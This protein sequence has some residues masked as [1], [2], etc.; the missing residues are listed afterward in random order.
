MARHAKVNSPLVDRHRGILEP[1]PPCP[2][3]SIS[4]RPSAAGCDSPSQVTFVP[5][6][7]QPV[8]HRLW[9]SNQA[10]MQSTGKM[11]V[12]CSLSGGVSLG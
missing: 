5:N 7:L 9:Q 6:S 8:F 10:R 11:Q 2:V 4:E 3:S 1:K 12:C